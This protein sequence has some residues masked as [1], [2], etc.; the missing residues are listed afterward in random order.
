M[1]KTEN[2]VNNKVLDI[3]RRT[4][5][6]KDLFQ[7]HRFTVRMVYNGGSGGWNLLQRED[8]KNMV[9]IFR[10]FI[11][12]EVDGHPFFSTSRLGIC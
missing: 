9:A 3:E 10:Y 4:S 1:L 6:K 5:A 8:L 11:G 2:F 12:L 7:L